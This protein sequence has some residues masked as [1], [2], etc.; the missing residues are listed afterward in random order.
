[1][2][3]VIVLSILAAVLLAAVR[4]M[5]KTKAKGGCSGCS[6]CSGNCS[7]CHYSCS[8]FAKQARENRACF[9]AKNSL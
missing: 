3:D 8:N 9:F 4:S 5:L 7:G 6:G 1:M 2:G